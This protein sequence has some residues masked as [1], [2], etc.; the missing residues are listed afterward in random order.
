MSLLFVS[1]VPGLPMHKADILGSMLC[2]FLVDVSVGDLL[3]F[4]E[5]L[6]VYYTSVLQFPCAEWVISG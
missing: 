4:V 3:S 5:A 6:Y 1:G 2:Q